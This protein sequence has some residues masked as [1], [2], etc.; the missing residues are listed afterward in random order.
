DLPQEA[1]S[2]PPGNAQRAIQPRNRVSRNGTTCPGPGTPPQ[3]SRS[4]STN[5]RPGAPGDVDVA[6]QPAPD[7]RDAGRLRQG[8]TTLRQEPGRASEQ[9]WAQPPQHAELQEQPGQAV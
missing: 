9:A 3:N 4:A 6:K 8:R 5:P 1:G 2:N 7:L